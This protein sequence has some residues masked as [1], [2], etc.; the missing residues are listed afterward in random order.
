MERFNKV[1]N[2]F[3][4]YWWLRVQVSAALQARGRC[5][6]CKYMRKK[7]R[8]TGRGAQIKRSGWKDE[9]RRED[10]CIHLAVSNKSKLPAFVFCE[11]VCRCFKETHMHQ[12]KQKSKPSDSI[13]P[14]CSCSPFLPPSTC[15][16]HFKH[17]T[18][19]MATSNAL[20]HQNRPLNSC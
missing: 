2:S 17:Q 8:W 15:P 13:S 4:A 19:A 11:R 9:E 1:L 12:Q 20:S 16:F 10:R 6:V 3:V 14:Q 7:W 18:V 5:D